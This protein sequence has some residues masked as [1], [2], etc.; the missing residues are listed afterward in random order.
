MAAQGTS[1][2]TA[3]PQAAPA[4]SGSGAGAGAGAGA[5]APVG[6]GVGVGGVV[7]DPWNQAWLDERLAAEDY[8][9]VVEYIVRSLDVDRDPRAVD[10]I[11]IQGCKKSHPFALY[12]VARNL[13]K[14]TTGRV[15]ALTDLHFGFKAAVLLLMRVYQDVK[16]CK[17]NMGRPHVD[18][19]YTAIRDKVKTWVLQHNGKHT[20][21][22]VANVMREIETWLGVERREYPLPTWCTSFSSPLVFGNTFNWG[23]P[24][25][26]DIAAFK[27]CT[28]IP[29]TRIAASRLF[30]EAL[31][32]AKSWEDVFSIPLCK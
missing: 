32:E 14:P 7:A 6:S 9:K 23:T 2:G 22:T 24:A 18:V 26:Y 21:P 4:G 20:T 10:W 16:A 12:Y 8:A 31:G 25:E 17:T 27:L 29:V 19:V 5:P 11:F 3:A 13:L 28:G 1:L 15:P 30:L